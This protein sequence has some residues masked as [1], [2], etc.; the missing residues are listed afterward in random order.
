MIALDAVVDAG[1]RPKAIAVRELDKVYR[2]ARDGSTVHALRG[3]TLSV[4]EGEFVALLGPS[5]CGK[6]TLLRILAGLL[7]YDS[8]A[9][10]VGGD[11]VDG[12]PRTD[13]G[14][15][16]QQPGL[17]PW[18]NVV[19]NVA[20]P[21]VVS[22]VSR[23]R[24][25][26]RARELLPMVGLS[27]FERAY[28]RELSGG[29]QQRVAIIRALVS[30]PKVLLLDEP[31]GALDAITR[32]NLNLEIHRIWRETSKTVF[33]VTHSV[34]EAVFLATHVFV[35]SARPGRI[36]A[37]HDVPFGEQRSK[38]ILDTER[39]VDHTRSLRQLLDKGEM[40]RD[41]GA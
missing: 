21:L 6:S 8:G 16:F 32:E 31:F 22:G 14:V 26:E 3:V 29:M 24:A 33:L 36:V 18:R 17:L 10:A 4:G 40:A 23:S 37:T 41:V 20:L 19:D 1:S 11:K 25:R 12:R 15:V 28:P 9:A 27:D 7:S 30:D 2:S 13:V 39:F 5:G 38:D 34:Q 35:M